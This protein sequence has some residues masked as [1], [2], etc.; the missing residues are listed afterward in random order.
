MA[1]SFRPFIRRRV[2][3]RSRPRSLPCRRPFTREPFGCTRSAACGDSRLAP[4]LGRLGR[5]GIAV[6]PVLGRRDRRCAVL[7]HELPAGGA[8]TDVR[9]GGRL[10]GGGG[11]T[12]S[13]VP[14]PTSPL[15]P[16]L[17]PRRTHDHRSRLAA[18]R[19]RG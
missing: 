19:S 10:E 13:S 7:P 5:G 14:P 1:P 16:R 12:P 8:G 18:C 2:S 4:A 9:G 11:R 17:G 3:S 6:R 15:P